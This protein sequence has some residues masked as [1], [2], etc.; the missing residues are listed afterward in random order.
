MND[1]I[2]LLS[3]EEYEKLREFIP[4]IKTWWWLRSP[5]YTDVLAAYVSGEGRVRE[6]GSNVQ[7]DEAWIR[8]A[9]KIN[10]YNGLQIGD[11]FV[12]ADFP[13]IIIAK[14]LAIAEVPIAFRRFDGESNSYEK[15]EIRWFLLDWYEERTKE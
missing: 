13:W 15:S 14:D 10:N 3:I 1:K 6:V 8:P 5:G 4:Q 9:L 12:E 7:L 2:F 11:R